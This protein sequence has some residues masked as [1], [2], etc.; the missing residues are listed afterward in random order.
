MSDE[1]TAQELIDE[2]MDSLH[3]AEDASDS[4][5]GE[6]VA[7]QQAYATAA[8]A[9]ALV[10]LRETMAASARTAAELSELV[11]KATG[12]L[13]DMHSSLTGITGVLADVRDMQ[14]RNS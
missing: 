12:L 11:G 14:A 6:A 9:K 10:E 2:V 5:R 13:G 1:K 4:V 3:Y 7:L 8:V